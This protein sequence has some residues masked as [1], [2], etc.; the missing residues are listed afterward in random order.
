[1]AGS[2]W[3]GAWHGGPDP[4]EEPVDIRRPVGGIC[5]DVLAGASAR[6]GL[7]RLLRSGTNGRDGLDALRQKAIRRARELRRDNR[8]DGTLDQARELLD[9]DLQAERSA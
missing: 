2:S 4:L 8:L 1:M 9:E 6:N 7:N 5:D 3:Y